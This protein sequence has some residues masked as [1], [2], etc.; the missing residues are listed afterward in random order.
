MT[1]GSDRKVWWV[2]DKG[3]RYQ[4]SVANRAKGKG[5][6]YC[7]GRKVLADFN[8]LETTSPEIAA[9]WHPTRNGDLTPRDVTSGSHTMVWWRCPVGHEWEAQ[10]KSRALQGTGCPYCSN[11]RVLKGYN[12]LESCYPEIAAEWD[13]EKNAGLDPNEVTYGSGKVVWWRCAKGHSWR[14]LVYRR[15][16]GRGCPECRKERK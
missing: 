6:P 16:E 4:A 15:I 10:I 8:D 11:K 3:H 5:C 13:S 7:T 12:D 9:E 1:S 2:C 14:M